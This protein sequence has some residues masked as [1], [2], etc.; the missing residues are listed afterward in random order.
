MT[1]MQLRSRL[2]HVSRRR[3]RPA[4]AFAIAI[5]IIVVFGIVLSIILWLSSG[6]KHSS[7][8]PN[9]LPH[10]SAQYQQLVVRQ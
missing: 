4:Y 1:N 5:A 10:H 3:G 8:D 6:P 9:R 7:N 2:Q